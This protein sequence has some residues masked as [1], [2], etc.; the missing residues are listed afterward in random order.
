MTKERPFGWVIESTHYHRPNM[1]SYKLV[2]GLTWTP[3]VGAY[4]PPSTLEHLQ[5]LEETLKSFKDPI[6]LGDLNVELDEARS[7]RIKQVGD[8]IAEYGLIDLVCH[9]RQRRSFQN[10]KTWSQVR[11]GT[12]LRLR[13]DYILR[14]DRRHFELV[15]ICDMRNFSLDHFTLRD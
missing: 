11:Q 13:C 5:D 10:L 8:L 14:T 15:E 2:S 3:L 6:I 1:V 4:L 7:P 9:F 12:V